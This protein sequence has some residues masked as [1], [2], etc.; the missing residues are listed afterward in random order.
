MLVFIY[1]ATFYNINLV[2]QA[3]KNQTRPILLYP[4]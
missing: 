4:W 1:S 2:R 3:T